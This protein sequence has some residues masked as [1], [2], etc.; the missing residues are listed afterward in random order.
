MNFIREEDLFGTEQLELDV[1]G[2]SPF[3]NFC[4]A[5]D[6]SFELH[7]PDFYRTS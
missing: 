2:S 3:G 1:T 7:D 4:L 5:L 6:G